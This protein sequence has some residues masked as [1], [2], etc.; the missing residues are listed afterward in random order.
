MLVLLNKEY[1]TTLMTNSDLFDRKAYKTA[2]L[3]QL[4]GN[5]TV[6]CVVTLIVLIASVMLNIGSIIDSIKASTLDY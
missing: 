6:A 3:S 1:F 2:A 5:W 4:K